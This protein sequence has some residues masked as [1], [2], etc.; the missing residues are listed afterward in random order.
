MWVQSLHQEDP[1]EQE[2]ASHSSSLAWK[3]PWTEK[4]CGLQSVRTHRVGHDRT[5][6]QIDDYHILDWAR[7]SVR[8]S[9]PFGENTRQNFFFFILCS[10]ITFPEPLRD[11]VRII[12]KI[13]AFHCS[14]SSDERQDRKVP[15]FREFDHYVILEGAL[16]FFSLGFHL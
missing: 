6:M 10:E 8:T 1:L 5:C 16:K 9:P 15:A 12:S 11:P 14:I 4:P 2:I 7:D 3:I 13:P